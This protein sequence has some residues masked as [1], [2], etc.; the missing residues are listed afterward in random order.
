MVQSPLINPAVMALPLRPRIACS[1]NVYRLY[2]MTTAHGGRF[3]AKPAPRFSVHT[4]RSVSCRHG[5][6]L[7][8]LAAHLIV[9]VHE[10]TFGIILP[11]PDVQFE[12]G[13]Q[14]VP[15]RAADELEG[16]TFKH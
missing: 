11:G 7:L 1:D 2:E 13:G 15:V 12:E 9:P 3:L 14:V 16:L 5:I 6:D 4:T 10:R 8:T